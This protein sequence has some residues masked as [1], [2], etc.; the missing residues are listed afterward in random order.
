M[1]TIGATYNKDGTLFLFKNRDLTADKVLPAPVIAEVGGRRYV[2]F[3][4]DSN[5]QQVG[6]W[7]GVNDAGL[8]I[9]GADGNC[10]NDLQGEEFGSGALTWEAYERVL[11]QCKNVLEAYDFLIDFY[12][13]RKIGG[14]GD[15]IV[16]ADRERAVAIE[17]SWNIWSLHFVKSP[18]YVVRTNF[19]LNLPHLR[20]MPE[21]SP[22]HLSSKVRYERAMALLSGFSTGVT[23]RNVKELLSDNVNGPGAFSICRSGGE[24]DY[25]TVATAIMDVGEKKVCAHYVVN[26]KPACDEFRCLTL[27]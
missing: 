9:V 18:S 22:V 26:G 3:G 23:A 25:R 15:I 4:V 19:F 12:Q 27:E 14:T 20:P 1:C 7:A 16:A 11:S 6:V 10:V 5:S 24:G 2:K 8:A 21:L 13:S 17:Y